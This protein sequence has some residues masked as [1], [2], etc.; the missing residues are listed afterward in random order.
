[1]HT[2]KPAAAAYLTPD[3]ILRDSSIITILGKHDTVMRFFSSIS[4]F[5]SS[6]ASA[7]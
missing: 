3:G 5:I 4:H 7:I 6:D 1:M 2:F